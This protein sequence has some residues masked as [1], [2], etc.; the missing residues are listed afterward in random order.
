M[1]T[2]SL[3]LALLAVALTLPSRPA[4][5]EGRR[6]GLLRNRPLLAKPLSAAERPAARDQQRPYD[7][8][9]SRPE[10]YPKYYGG[11][12]YRELQN[13]GYPSGDIGIRGS[14]W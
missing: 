7:A 5:A 12:H 13:L 9:W 4:Q 1:R 8:F 14:A 11:F 2:R 10:L 6:P 3:V